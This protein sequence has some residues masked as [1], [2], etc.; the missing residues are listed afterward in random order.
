MAKRWIAVE[1][2]D[3]TACEPCAQVDGTLYRSRAAAYADDPGGVGYKDCV[4]AQFGNACRGKVVKRRGAESA[5]DSSM[6]RHTARVQN[7]LA[8]T[9]KI[10]AQARA[11]QHAPETREQRPKDWFRIENATA[12]EATVYIYDEIGFWG[13]SAQGFVDQLNALT[14]PKLSI[15][16]NS[17]GGEVFDGVA[18]HSALMAS[19]AHVTVFIDG[20]AASAASFIAMAGDRI[21]MA[22]HATMM[23]HD[24]SGLCWG[25]PADMEAMGG[26]LAK[27]SDN[28]ADMYSLQAGGTVQEW[29]ARMQAETWYTGQEALAAGL[30]DEI[31]S[32]D[33]EEEISE[34][35]SPRN[36]LSLAAFNFSGRAEAPAPEIPEPSPESE[37]E[38]AEDWEEPRP[39]GHECSS[40][41]THTRPAEETS[42]QDTPEFEREMRMAL[43]AAALKG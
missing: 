13:T 1:E 27:L 25:N 42:P 28:I 9:A 2:D 17:P 34:E 10:A 40:E 38:R 33:E 7:L 30:V 35:N 32:P 39:E 11:V 15:R 19:K 22:R 20:L 5:E 16:I 43:L 18:I 8:D 6:K 31:T 21:V 12:E 29:R 24:A 41:C 14:A 36:R 37:E 4:G 26:L 23:I 3:D